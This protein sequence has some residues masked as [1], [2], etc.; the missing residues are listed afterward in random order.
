MHHYKDVMICDNC[1]FQNG[2]KQLGM[3]NKLAYFYIL[4][5]H[6]LRYLG[7]KKII[8]WNKHPKTQNCRIGIF[9]LLSFLDLISQPVPQ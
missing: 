9:Y 8:I 4:E 5:L 1:N 7:T 6:L 3:F 2:H